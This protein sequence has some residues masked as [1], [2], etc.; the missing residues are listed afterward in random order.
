MAKI[1][2][3]F[4]ETH[5][6]THNLSD[7][8]SMAGLLAEAGHQIVQK[9][10]QADLIIINTCTVKTPTEHSML[11]RIAQLKKGRKKIV[12][13]GCI[14]Q[15]DPEKLKGVSIIGT[16]Q[17]SRIAEVVNATLEGKITSL[18]SPSSASNLLSPKIR[19]NPLIEI[20][21]ISTG[22]LG[23]CSFCKTKAA[24]GHLKSHP[25][26]EIVQQVRN[27]TSSGAKEI[28]LT[29]QDTACYGFDI[30]TN[31]ADLLKEICKIDKDFK[32][33]LAATALKA[34]TSSSM[35]LAFSGKVDT[36]RNEMFSFGG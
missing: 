9:E 23:A 13:A 15:T 6:C 3:I 24:R 7:S 29:S 4:I 8:E 12:V 20:I 33:R 17:I 19:K 26:K 28:W 32:I 22:C 30:K 36:R 16:S 21:P 18:T 34:L 11:S 10:I 1:A 25:V 35:G 27:A 31:V 5:G 14:P 2:K